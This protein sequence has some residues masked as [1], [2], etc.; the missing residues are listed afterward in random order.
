MWKRIFLF[1]TAALILLFG[2]GFAYLYFRK[3]A[4]AP[5]SSTRVASTPERLAR[6]KYL[7]ET[8][9]DCGGCHS[10]RDF[11]R[12][13]APEVVSGRG[14]GFIFPD[15][16]AFPGRV[17][18]SNITPDHDTGIGSWSDGEKIRAIREGIGRD[19]RTLFPLMPYTYYRHMSDADV[20]SLVAYLNALPPV[21]RALPKTEIRFP[22][23]L[24][25]KSA[26]Q[27]AGTVGLPDRNDRVKYGEYLVRMGGC[28]DCHTA[29]EKGRPAEDK[30]LA[31]GREFRTPWGVVVSANITPHDSG[32]GPW[33]EQ[34][35]INKFA[36]YKEYAQ[37]GPPKVS[38]A[39]FTLMPWLN[40]SQLPDEDLGAIFTFLKTQKPVLNRVETHPGYPKDSVT[41]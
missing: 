21:R 29:I 11:T 36:E 34:Q 10:L 26:P 14:Q 37:T 4:Q 24:F 20:E 38:P 7:F 22:V 28:I 5:P 9:C 6:G 15:E 3:P 2:G 16:F 8:L 17:V 39:S 27:P 25:I 31:G 30:I 32:I 35:F 13:D 33:G 12:F 19:G 40:F 23:N 1:L 41:K 18:A